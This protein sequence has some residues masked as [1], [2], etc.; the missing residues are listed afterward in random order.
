MPLA[1]V[2]AAGK[3]GTGIAIPE[4]VQTAAGDRVRIPLLVFFL[5]WLAILPA[6]ASEPDLCGASIDRAETAYRLPQRLL[7]SVALVES[8]RYNAADREKYAWPWTI[9][10][11]GKGQF[12]ATKAEAVAEV[13][14]LRRRGVRS[15]DVGCMQV[16]LH[17]HPNAFASLEEAFDPAAN[18]DYAARFLVDLKEKARSWT[19]AVA[20]YHSQTEA[21]NRPY[22]AKVMQVWGEEVRRDSESRRLAL[23][24]AWQERRAV[25]VSQAEAR[26]AERQA[27]LN[28]ARARS[29]Q[30]AQIRVSSVR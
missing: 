4:G 13:Q 9:N 6:Q 19:Q 12:F 28:V 15:I 17:F 7:A 20:F 22:K 25:A 21:L 2:D 29:Q 26:A 16:N 18:V 8:G 30:L 24:S 5:V 1:L 10:A 3:S 23:V 11:G 27:A 14:R